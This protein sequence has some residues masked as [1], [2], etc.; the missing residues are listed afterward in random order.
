MTGN[1]SEE[2]E[3]TKQKPLQ[4]A[5]SS[6]ASDRERELRKLEVNREKDVETALMEKAIAIHQKSLEEFAARAAAEEARMRATE[7]TE[8]VRLIT[9]AL[10]AL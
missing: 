7:A 2:Q 8:R 4:S 10:A 1:C 9:A 6:W 3:S 5:S